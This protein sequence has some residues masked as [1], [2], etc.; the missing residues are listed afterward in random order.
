[1][2]NKIPAV[3]AFIIFFSM[4]A[5][6]ADSQWLYGIHWYGPQSN[7]A[8][9][10]A[11]TGGKKIWSLETV[12][13][14]DGT[15]VWGPEGQFENLKA[16]AAQGHTLIIR[17]Q[18][19][20]GKAFPL[21][22]DT[23]PSMA[24]FLD[25]VTQTAT[26]YRN[27]CHIWLLGNEMNFKTEWGGQK[28]QP[29]NYINAASQFSER[30]KSVNSSLGPQTVLV[31]A[32]A[33]GDTLDAN[34]WMTNSDYLNR[35]CQAIRDQSAES[36]FDGFALHAYGNLLEGPD[37]ADVTGCLQLFESKP[38]FGYQDQ[39][40]ILDA[41]GFQDKPIYITEWN[42]YTKDGNTPDEYQSA[43]FLSAAFAGIHA[44]NQN[45]HPVTAACWFIY[46]DYGGWEG[47]SLNALK[48]NDTPDH[49]I[50]HA[51]QSACEQDY[52]ARYPVSSKQP[53]WLVH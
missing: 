46:H 52:P 1:M 15:D 27:I 33:C 48:S 2:N 25:Q 24:Q 18:P 21:P 31:G 29:E 47:F 7:Q 39:I 3:L 8:D 6:G 49:D 13:T 22:G 30:I 43:Q 38:A 34:M 11:M 14:N 45:H 26:L 9:L 51:F 32:A 35:M 12:M 50:W 41:H 4:P 5:S 16:V 10:N 37:P 40:A 42:R 36:K 53:V 44:W 20:W 17:L 19:I 28:L 23:A